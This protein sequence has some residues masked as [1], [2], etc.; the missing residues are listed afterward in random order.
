MNDDELLTA[1]REALDR[2]EQD[3]ARYAAAIAVLDGSV[4]I[5][6]DNETAIEVVAPREPTTPNPGVSE[7]PAKGKSPVIGDSVRCDVCGQEF[8]RPNGLTRHLRQTHGIIRGSTRHLRQTHG[9]IRGSKTSAEPSAPVDIKSS[10]LPP[11]WADM[12]AAL[13]DRPDFPSLGPIERTPFDPERARV[14][15]GAAL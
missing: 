8:S 11:G 14:A 6:V 5:E 3:A 9:I 1:L 10:K 13:D 4:G 2:A 7:R 12:G 15:A